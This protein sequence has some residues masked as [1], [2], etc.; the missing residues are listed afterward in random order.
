MVGLNDALRPA[1]E[2]TVRVRRLDGS[3][4][5]FQAIARVDSPVEVDYLKH[6]GILQMVLRNLLK[7]TVRTR[8]V[9]A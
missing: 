5:E 2:L 1:Q 9:T 8:E 4:S 3:T 6:G 7:D